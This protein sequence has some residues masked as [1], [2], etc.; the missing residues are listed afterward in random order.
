[1]IH[2]WADGEHD[3]QLGAFFNVESEHLAVGRSQRF[4]R[5]CHRVRGQR[6]TPT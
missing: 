3:N 1:M 5:R 2:A 4:G 6:A